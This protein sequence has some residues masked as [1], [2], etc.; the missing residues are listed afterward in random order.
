VESLGTLNACTQQTSIPALAPIVRFAGEYRWS[1]S[2]ENGSPSSGFGSARDP[3][4]EE[5]A[6]PGYILVVEDNSGD[7]EL[8]RWSI[9]EHD[10][11]MDL[12]VVTDGEQAIRLVQLMDA[13]AKPCPA[14]IVL[15]LNLPKR[16]GLE[17][18]R[19]IR[20]SLECRTT[21]VAVFS[22]SNASKDMQD[23]ARL[24]ANKYIRKPSN[25]QDFL[26][27]GGQ[28]KSL[29]GERMQ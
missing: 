15:D 5:K 21:P 14:L 6:K 1:L 18:L 29:L 27:I 8:L 26:A 23:S 2:P 12:L 28:L 11:Q 19:Y 16:T 9:R 25:L 24:G 10:I 22:S 3:R 7:A 20:H 17:V 13:G 4:A